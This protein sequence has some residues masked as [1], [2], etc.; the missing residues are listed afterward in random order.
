MDANC[1]ATNECNTSHQDR[2]EVSPI[3][4]IAISIVHMTVVIV[5][6]TSLGTIILYNVYAHKEFKTRDPITAL[7]CAVT[8]SCM[9]SPWVYSMLLDISMITNLPLLG[10]C[11][12]LGFR[13]VRATAQV[14]LR[15]F[16]PNQLALI[17]CTQFMVIK[18]GKKHVTV[19]RVLAAFGIIA[20][21][22]AAVA[23][24]AVVPSIGALEVDVP[25]VR[26]SWCVQNGVFRRNSIIQSVAFTGLVYLFPAAL[27]VIF[28]IRSYKMVKRSMAE[29]DKIVR[30]VLLVSAATLTVQFVLKLPFLVTL[31][32]SW[33][34]DSIALLY[35]SAI[36]VDVEY[37]CA[38]LLIITTH[39][40]IRNAVF[41][42][43]IVK[44]FIHPN[45][46]VPENGP[47][48]LESSPLPCSNHSITTQTQVT[49]PL[50]I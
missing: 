30:S 46:V 14:F 37:C 8:I 12:S 36:M 5:P 43:V 33:V 28:S 29:K 20:A 24:L 31:F 22:T 44:C 15:I 16:T 23:F 11:S 48:I 50:P 6:T 49:T 25:T 21:I 35:F 7:F 26:G 10:S 3:P 39:R 41:S 9:L 27:I 40:G 34:V 1:T 42:K 18:H 13:L 4:F 47:E 32:M 19:G 2:D 38:L 17:T 45:T